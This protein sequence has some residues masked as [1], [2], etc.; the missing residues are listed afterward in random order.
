MV[1]RAEKI[2]PIESIRPI[3]SQKQQERSIQDHV[4]TL[5]RSKTVTPAHQT[6]KP[7]LSPPIWETLNNVNRLE[8]VNY[9]YTLLKKDRINNIC[10]QIK[11]LQV[12]EIEKL[13]EV[14]TA[15]EEM[16]YWGHLYD[17]GN[18]IA[19]S[20]SFFFGF[21]AVSSGGTAV[22]AALITSGIL[23]L[24]NIA[25]KHAEA[26]DWVADQ[27]SSGDQETHDAI[28]TYLPIAIGIVAAAMGAYG[29]YGTWNLPQ[30]QGVSKGLAILET[31][32]GV[33]Q[34]IS[35]WRNGQ[36]AQKFRTAGAE[37]SALQTKGELVNL[38]VDDVMDDIKKLQKDL[39]LVHEMIGRLIQDASHSIQSIQQPV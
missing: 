5:N 26:W 24:S 11:K 37:V 36:A 39:G 7:I 10:E 2:S 15:S 28:K 38:D 4:S 3:S 30:M 27:F 1:N 31:T 22:G 8:S 21:A 16:T 6:S 20:V 12:E 23:S 14:S 32:A 19:S 34:A 18:A 29:A 33:T 13:E 17:A 25:F 35:A 9:D